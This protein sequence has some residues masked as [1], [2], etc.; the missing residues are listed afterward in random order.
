[1]KCSM[2]VVTLLQ[3]TLACKP[4]AGDLKD[5]EKLS[6]RVIGDDTF[7][8]VSVA[9]SLSCLPGTRLSS[10]MH[11]TRVQPAVSPTHALG[12]KPFL[13]VCITVPHILCA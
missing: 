5:I 2:L 3:G 12:M 1:M 11:Q 9:R 10:L 6:S 4:V 7:E 13:N 8:A